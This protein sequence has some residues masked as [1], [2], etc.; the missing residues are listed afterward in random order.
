V[1]GVLL[2]LQSDTVATHCFDQL[3]SYNVISQEID[4]LINTATAT[5]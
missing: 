5:I 4:A 3:Q 1:L 2:G